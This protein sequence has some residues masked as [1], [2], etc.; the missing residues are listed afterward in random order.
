MMTTKTEAWTLSEKKSQLY[1]TRDNKDA[2]G[3]MDSI[4]RRKPI[5]CT[6]T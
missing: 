6:L 3:S 5:I 2:D 1:T 4:R